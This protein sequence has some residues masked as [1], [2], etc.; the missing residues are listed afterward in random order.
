MLPSGVRDH[1]LYLR[2]AGLEQ[3]AIANGKEE[4]KR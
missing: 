3:L 1:E 4:H 2:R